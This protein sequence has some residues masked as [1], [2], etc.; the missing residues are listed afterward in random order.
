M[1]SLTKWVGFVLGASGS[2]S[3]R[4]QWSYTSLKK[5]EERER[6]R[7]MVRERERE[8]NGCETWT[9][10]SVFCDHRYMQAM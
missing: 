10:N 2:A 4:M 5:K 1:V 3:C 7:E 8:R 9:E 6:E